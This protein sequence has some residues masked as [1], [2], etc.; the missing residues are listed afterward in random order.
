MTPKTQPVFIILFAFLVSCI[1]I[2]PAIAEEFEDDF[3]TIT[4]QD[5]GLIQEQTINI[6]NGTGFVVDTINTSG[7]VTLPTNTTGFYTFQMKPTPG[8]MSGTSMLDQIQTLLTTYWW[9]MIFVLLGFILLR[10][11]K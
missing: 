2:S 3:I 11:K 1:L 4:F 6:Y 9:L 5:L 7:T 10:G 8:N